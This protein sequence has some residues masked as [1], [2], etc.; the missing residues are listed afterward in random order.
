MSTLSTHRKRGGEIQ[1]TSLDVSKHFLCRLLCRLARSCGLHNGGD[2][3]QTFFGSRRERQRSV[4][5]LFAIAVESFPMIRTGQNPA[6]GEGPI[7]GMV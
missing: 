5:R 6:A 4:P 1:I 7:T 2:E 3:I